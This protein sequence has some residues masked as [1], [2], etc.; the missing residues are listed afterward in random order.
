MRGVGQLREEEVV[1][2]PLVHQYIDAHPYCFVDE[3]NIV[4]SNPKVPKVMQAP[5]TF[6]NVTEVVGVSWQW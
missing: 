2:N 1:L 4:L 6:A 3:N 5:P